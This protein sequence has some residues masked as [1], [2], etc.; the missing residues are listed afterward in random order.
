VRYR[1]EYL[2]QTGEGDAVC[3]IVEA[4]GNLELAELQARLNGESMRRAFHAGGF[5]IR[6]LED[7]GRIV[8]LENFEDPLARFWPY[9]S[10][11]VIH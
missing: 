9:A 6:D 2:T 5:Q 11:H 3:Q 4:E 1:I 7:G 10:D 8:A